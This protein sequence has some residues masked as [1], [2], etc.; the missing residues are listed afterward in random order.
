ME[1][2]LEKID[3]PEKGF[4]ADGE[5]NRIAG[6]VVYTD[7]AYLKRRARVST[8]EAV[9]RFFIEVR[10]FSVVVDSVQASVYGKG[11]ILSVQYREI[12]VKY[13]PQPEIR[14]LETKKEALDRDR[15]LL[16]HRRTVAEKQTR[17]L[18]SV[19]GFAEV[20]VP[21]KIK[22]QFPTPENL[23]TMLGF[24]GDN[25]GKL[26]EAELELR[27]QIQEV[28]REIAVIDRRL[29]TLRRPRKKARRVIEVVFNAACNQEIDIEVS[30]AAL[31]A[32]WEPVYKV[33]VPLDLSEVGM[34]MFA[35]IQQNTG[36]NW[37][38]VEVAVS[39]AI[40]IKG[41]SL[42]DLKSWHLHFPTENLVLGAAPVPVAAAAGELSETELMDEA[43]DVSVGEGAAPEAEFQQAE[44]RELPLA[45]EY[46]LPQPVSIGSGDAETLLPL[47]TQKLDGQFFIHAVPRNDP[48]AYLVCRIAPDN[49]LLAGRLNVYFGGRFVGGTV[50]TEKKA[51]EDLLV[52]LGAERGVKMQRETITDKMAETFFG[53]VE[54][55]MVAR[56]LQYR[57]R[58]EN[59]K[60]VP[61]KIEL[62]DGVPVSTTDRIQIKGVELTPSPTQKDF[63]KREGVMKW[64]LQLKP[65]T[66]QDI[67]VK[68]FVKHP[69]NQKPRGL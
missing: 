17:F 15:K 49:T 32:S 2:R 65:N 55:A 6:V 22:T 14:E 8:R 38:G 45:F 44:Q 23:D 68:F 31:S 53:K 50:F 51:G 60:A 16:R 47:F 9:N 61:V 36:E 28:D 41:A 10:A 5:N 46:A 13:S 4:I 25:Y 69:R 66:V 58:L 7:Q 11:E 24:L 40:P 42:P 52:N 26:A 35:H 3:D 62:Y 37:E 67:H 64:E 56:E 19:V 18:D 27:N 20:E 30:Y 63:E 39:N 54:R 48:L 34:A 12:P 33:D 57:I 21:K 59:L 43:F 1:D 29:K